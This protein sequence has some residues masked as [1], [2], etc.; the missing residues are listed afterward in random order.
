MGGFSLED[1]QGATISDIFYGPP[2]IN[3]TPSVET[4]R[5]STEFSQG[6]EEMLFQR[7]FSQEREDVAM[8]EEEGGKEEEEEEEEKEGGGGG[9]GG[10][11][12]RRRWKKRRKE[13][14]LK[15]I[16]KMRRRKRKRRRRRW[17]RMWW[18]ERDL[19]GVQSSKRGPSG[20]CCHSVLV[21]RAASRLLPP[22]CKAPHT[23][24][25]RGTK[26][27]ELLIDLIPKEPEFPLG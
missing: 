27:V 18:R 9:G 15:V 13:G 17:R 11:I 23:T 2:G 8:E 26:R 19:S 16:L 21:S 20:S 24:R 3:R 4:E 12:R 10:G 5:D 6:E 1:A 22:H 14:G 25:K 7:V